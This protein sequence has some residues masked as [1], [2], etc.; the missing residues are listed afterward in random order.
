MTFNHLLLA[1]V[2][3]LPGVALA[4]NCPNLM[5]EIDAALAADPQLDEATKDEVAQLR[6]IG[7]EQHTAGEHE[8]AEESL[9]DAL[10]LLDKR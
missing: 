7:E 8:A 1:L 3:T 10:T 9:S 4:H 6:S 5:A 2:L